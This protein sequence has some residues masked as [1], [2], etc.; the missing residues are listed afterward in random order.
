[1]IGNSKN[2][3]ENYPE[4]A[5]EHKKKKPGLNLTPG[6]AS[7]GLRTTRPDYLLLIHAQ[8]VVR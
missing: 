6:K 1:M 5:F 2:I 4:K 3:R 7:I 8:I